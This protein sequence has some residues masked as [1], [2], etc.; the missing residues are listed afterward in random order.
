[1]VAVFMNGILGKTVKVS[2]D[3]IAT[4]YVCPFLD[5]QFMEIVT[6]YFLP[7]CKI[8]KIASLT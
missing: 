4:G 6:G 8:S 1:M 3:F 2:G 7:S 5:I